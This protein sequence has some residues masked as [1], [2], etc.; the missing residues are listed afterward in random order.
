MGTP[1]KWKEGILDALGQLT[2]AGDQVIVTLLEAVA[3]RQ[4][5]REEPFDGPDELVYKVKEKFPMRG[6][7]PDIRD[8]CTKI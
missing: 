4:K 8:S 2:L 1:P 7:S 5:D 6:S 3:S